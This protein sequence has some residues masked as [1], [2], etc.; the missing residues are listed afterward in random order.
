M[1]ATDQNGRI[2]PAPDG[3][4]RLEFARHLPHPVAAVW[5]GITEPEHRAAWIGPA[6]VEGRV[7]G[8]VTTEPDDPP[9]KPEAKR[10]TGEVLTWEPER[11]F[12]HTWH[13]R[14]VEPG[15]VAYELEADG[16]GTLVRFRHEGLSPRN[17]AG[18][19]PGTHAYLDRLAAHLAGDPV[20]GWRE[21]FA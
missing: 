16:D 15:R 4:A 8:T 17:A 7:G 21:R 18:F 9:V 20:P 12:A 6:T 5:A 11:A 14:I 3:T 1:A 19:I 10:M 2:V 13:Q